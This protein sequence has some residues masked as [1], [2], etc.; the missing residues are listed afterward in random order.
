[1]QKPSDLDCFVGIG[2]RT[3][4]LR[5]VLAT[6]PKIGWLE[7]HA[8]NYFG[9]GPAV[10]ALDALRRDY[11]ISL[12]G[13]GLS[14]GSAEGLDRDHLRRLCALDSRVEPFLV[15]EHLAW[16]TVDRIYL[17][18]LLPLPYTQEA[19]QVVATNL[20]AAQ[21]A[22]GRCLAV[23]NP[24][25][26]LKF[27]HSTIPEAEFL[28]E[29]VRR[30]GCRILC[31]VNNIEVSAVNVDLERHAYLDALPRGAIAEIHVAGHARLEREGRTMAID[32]HGSC[33]SPEVISLYRC[34]LARFG[35]IPT[36]LEWDTRIPELPVLLAEAGKVERVA[37]SRFATS[38]KPA[39]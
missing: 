16:S 27:R 12:H 26:Y 11:P 9:D 38:V 15:S 6:R 37:R 14:L 2:L 10:A 39:C 36:L 22:L 17:N 29:L 23:E 24:A 5:E 18:D 33:V 19:L 21:E 30:T 28:G 34:A 3:P 4:H 7:I 32:D 25:R 8:E 13:V 35:R 31:D 1:M 20:A